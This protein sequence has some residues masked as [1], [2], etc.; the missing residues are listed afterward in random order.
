MFARDKHSL[1][2]IRRHIV[3]FIAR[4]TRD[5]G[6]GKGIIGLSGGVDSAVSYAV[7]CEALGPENTIG[8]IMSSA[9]STAESK[10]YAESV[11]QKFGGTLRRYDITQL[12]EA[13]RSLLDERS[14]ARLGNIQARIRMIILY[15]VSSETGGLVI[16][17]G[18]RS[19][20]LTGYF[21]Q[22]GDG[23][24]AV[25]PLGELYKTE[26]WA[27][28]KEL[29]IPEAVLD[30]P[31]TAELWEDQTDEGEIGVPYET[32]DEVLF[33]LIENNH[34]PTEIIS[35]GYD[36]DTVKR[37]VD[38][39]VRSKFKRHTPPVPGIRSNNRETFL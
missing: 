34:S 30:R 13:F 17:T 4:Y 8:V 27:L 28:G 35:L 39:V 3:E 32:L 29:G 19:E 7:T 6:A 36:H 14:K 9:F 15:N 18:N 25:E 5:A 11:V 37:V 31:P 20:L 23:G 2:R 33:L 1:Q 38:L 12:V 10:M 16:G 21:T 24:C 26:V 22:Y